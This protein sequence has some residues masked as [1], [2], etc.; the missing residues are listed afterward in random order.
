[1]LA[2]GPTTAPQA[3]TELELGVGEDDAVVAGQLLRAG[4]DH[5]GEVAQLLGGIRADVA[6]DCLE[7][8]VLV[9]VPDGSLGGGREQRMWKTAAVDQSAWEGDAADL[10]G[11]LVVQQ[12]RAGQVAPAHTLAR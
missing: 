8:D 12:P 3:G 4:V 1:E 10:P 2:S 6:D 9:V 5:Q 11:G 7:R